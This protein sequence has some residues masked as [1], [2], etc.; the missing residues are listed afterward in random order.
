VLYLPTYRRIEKELRSLLPDIDLESAFTSS[1]KAREETRKQEYIELV[2][3]GM[4][5]VQQTLDRALDDIGRNWRAELNRLTGEYLRDVIR[6]Q[7]RQGKPEELASPEV[8]KAV[9][10]ALARIDDAT[11]SKDDRDDLRKLL[12]QIQQRQSLESERMIAAHFLAKL[13]SIQG[14]QQAREQPIRDFANV[15]NTNYLSDK[16]FAFKA[17]TFEMPLRRGRVSLEESSLAGQEI[18][19]QGLSSGE[20]QLVSLFSHIYLSGQS[21][22]FVLID[23]PELSISVPWQKTLLK[24]VVATG[25]CTG[26]I[27]VTHSPFIFENELGEY[28]HSMHEYL[29]PASVVVP[30]KQHV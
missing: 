19:I 26:L 1:M 15:V 14:A 3:F 9:E 13:V 27:A 30:G 17:L 7:H 21:S 6:G 29:K 23:E 20:K 18:P 22:F 12:K 10:A 5:D 11:L 24:D 28:A 16:H 25:R 4:T 2:E 8:G